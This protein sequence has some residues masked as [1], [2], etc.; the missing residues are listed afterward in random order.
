MPGRRS[1]A[2]ARI[3]LRGA[4]GGVMV[5]TAGAQALT[6]RLGLLPSR[7]TGLPPAAGTVRDRQDRGSPRRLRDGS[8]GTAVAV[9][10][11]R[12]GGLTS[13]RRR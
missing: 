6:R 8:A 1:G 3:G 2:I 4:A 13:A 5:V 12:D 9:S 11:S 7:R 10:G